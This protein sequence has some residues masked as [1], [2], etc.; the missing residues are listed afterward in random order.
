MPDH[1]Q[2]DQ[3]INIFFDHAHYV[4]FIIPYMI[5][6]SVDLKAGVKTGNH[7]LL[8]KYKRLG[9]KVLHSDVFP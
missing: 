2:R 7:L 4:K 5:V 8:C 1:L 3:N 9:K 6:L